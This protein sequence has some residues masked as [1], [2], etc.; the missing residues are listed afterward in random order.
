LI[1]SAALSVFA[2]V[3]VR[4]E[5][6]QSSA[7]A[8]RTAA[9]IGI[10]L[11][12][13]LAVLCFGANPF[14]QFDFAMADGRGLEAR[15]QTIGF[16]V[17]PPLEALAYAS[18]VV[19]C[20][21][22][23]NPNARVRVGNWTRLASVFLTLA[24]AAR[25]WWTYTALEGARFWLWGVADCAALLLWLLVGALRHDTGA[26]RT[27]D[28]RG[29]SLIIVLMFAGAIVGIVFG[30]SPS[31]LPGASTLASDDL[32]PRLLVA[33]GIIAVPGFAVLR[34]LRR[35]SPANDAP[36]KLA[37]RRIDAAVV[38][39][40]ALV[41]LA[42]MVVVAV[43]GPL[44]EGWVEGTR[45]DASTLG[46]TTLEIAAPLL[47]IALTFAPRTSPRH[48]QPWRLR[49]LGVPLL[50]AGAVSVLLTLHGI[51]SLYALIT[52]ILSVL[53]LCMI[54]RDFV[55]GGSAAATQALVHAGVVL[56]VAGLCFSTLSSQRELTAKSGDTLATRDPFGRR[57]TLIGQGV[58]LYDVLNR[59]IIAVTLDAFR[60][61]VDEGLV[62]T[63]KRQVVDE[64][65]ASLGEPLTGIGLLRTATEDVR[66]ELL[67]AS[68][69]V[70]KVR[71]SFVPFAGLVWLG[72]LLAMLG[73]V[74]DMAFGKRGRE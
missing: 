56:A 19:S 35:R 20:A 8:A 68:G 63:E 12:I 27:A 45:P 6:T 2:W 43:V 32:S 58:S 53:A 4:G 61:G 3:A 25:M 52:T 57:W 71:V 29:T 18:I 48:A 42:A 62:K 37:A 23:V 59:R 64:H 26:R 65:G 17:V 69:E 66:L 55:L 5:L 9:M 7:S 60:E 49:T 73:G 30:G 15:L 34:S 41:T 72:A 51:T 14:A 33:V 46:D 40:G 38:G 11:F 44:V 16:V 74:V 13:V 50:L 10:P 24:V 39:T 36:P 67:D 21:L 1:W 47:L 22:W 28:S 70:A 54:V 31:M